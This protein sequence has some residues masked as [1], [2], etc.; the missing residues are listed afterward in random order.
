MRLLSEDFEDEVRDSQSKNPIAITWVISFEYIRSHFP[1]AA[2]SL[3]RMSMADA[4]AIPG[5]LIQRDG[6]DIIS[7]SKAIG[8][9]RAFCFISERQ[10]SEE[11]DL[12]SRLFDLHRLVRLAMRNWFKT[13]HEF[14]QCLL[15]IAEIFTYKSYRREESLK[16]NIS[17]LIMPHIMEILKADQLQ[18]SN[19]TMSLSETISN[20]KLW[21]NGHLFG[22]AWN[23]ETES[24]DKDKDD[25][26]EYGD[27]AEGIDDAKKTTTPTMAKTRMTTI[28]RL[29]ITHQNY[30]AMLLVGFLRFQPLH[31]RR[32]TRPKA[33]KL[34]RKLA[35]QVV[36]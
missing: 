28:L 7:F 17:S 21:N 31:K 14:H 27:T 20:S 6:E 34:V 22:D 35:L 2:E 24:D 10:K 26:P 32:S 8:T 11:A 25:H 18:P 3:S 9:L 29:S 12:Q 30:S 16:Y 13:N 5:F 15:R 19:G 36:V 4:Q 33:Y 1:Q 23:E